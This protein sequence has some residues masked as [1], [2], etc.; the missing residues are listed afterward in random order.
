MN[1]SL[2]LEELKKDNKVTEKSWHKEGMYLELQNPNNLSKMTAPYVYTIID[3]DYRIPWHTSQ[4]DI[5]EED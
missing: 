3:H 2:A 4:S 5:L 1:F